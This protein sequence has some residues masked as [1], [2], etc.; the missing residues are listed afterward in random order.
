M[1]AVL[2]C[3]TAVDAQGIPERVSTLENGVANLGS[4]FN[5]LLA[6]LEV[7]EEQAR[8]SYLTKLIEERQFQYN[9]DIDRA[10]SIGNT[11]KYTA[12]FNE[13]VDRIMS[14]FCPTA[15]SWAAFVNAV[16]V[17]AATD[18]NSIR[19]V[20]MAVSANNYANFS[21]HIIT[22]VKVEIY[23]TD[24]GVTQALLNASIDQMQ[25]K[26]VKDSAGVKIPTFSHS[27]GWY[28]NTWV[29]LPDNTVCMSDFQAWTI[30]NFDQPN[31]NAYNIVLD[32]LVL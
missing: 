15:P 10:F 31:T 4:Q 26:W 22:N 2:L 9:R 24:E 12:V 11:L 8:L 14:A 23:T 21:R 18:F 30:G 25:I 6:R 1:F 19:N 5:Q 7:A 32:P 13:S 17:L 28:H 29:V 16:P 27:V 20:Y 3:G